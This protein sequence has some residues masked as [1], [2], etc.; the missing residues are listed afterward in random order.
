MNKTDFVINALTLQKL[1]SN[2]FIIQT[3]AIKELDQKLEDLLARGACGAIVVSRTRVGKTCG[4]IYV[5]NCF[6]EYYGK[7]FPVIMWDVTDHAVTQKNFYSTL[8]TAMGV[9]HKTNS[10]A[11]TLRE[12]TLNELVLR[13]NNT[14][15][16]KVVIM[17]DE[18]WRFA[19]NDFS[20]F[21]LIVLEKRDL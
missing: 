2:D 21:I 20:S 18:A 17:I 11:L 16:H 12:R 6:Q 8:L 9:P 7:D 19:E 15:F 14:I 1:K 5:K 13:A 10:T 3:K 4:A